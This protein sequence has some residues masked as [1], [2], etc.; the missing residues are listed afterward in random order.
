M[1]PSVGS[2][3]GLAGQVG[4]SLISGTGI[5]HDCILISRSRP[6][7]RLITL[8]LHLSISGRCSEYPLMVLLVISSGR[9]HLSSVKALRVRRAA[10]MHSVSGLIKFLVFIYTIGFVHKYN[11]WSQAVIIIWWCTQ[12]VSYKWYSW[13]AFSNWRQQDVNLKPKVGT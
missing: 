6:V 3:N 5:C 8:S 10:L 4:L 12:S 1:S 13:E 7:W 11:N 9:Y 2:P